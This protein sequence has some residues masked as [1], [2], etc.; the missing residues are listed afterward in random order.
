VRIG[1]IAA[2]PD[3][4][5]LGC[6]AT[7]ARLAL[8]HEVHVALLGEGFA[9]RA[10]TRDSAV[11]AALKRL[12]EAA[13]QVA[14][15]LGVRSLTLAS[16]PDNQF[17]R[18]ALLDIVRWVEGWLAEVRPTVVYTHHPGDLNVDHRLTF[19]AL[20]TATR[21]VPGCTVRE[22]YTFEAPSSTEWAFQRLEPAFRPNTF[23]D[24]SDTIELKIKALEAYAGEAR[25]F[26]HPRSP[27]AL[28]AASQRWGSVAGVPNAEAFELI[29]AVR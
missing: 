2:H 27:D 1:V 11:E 21:P 4:E 28:R 3:D 29:R 6:G 18:V 8:E 17:D 10:V 5:V 25:P 20:L 19:Q 12:H 16:L 23:V 13:H 24:V 14:S 7:M 15:M 9:S 26:P 22:V